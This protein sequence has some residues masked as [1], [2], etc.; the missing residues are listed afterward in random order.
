[1]LL[2]D[3]IFQPNK[4]LSIY[5]PCSYVN[6]VD[7]GI[8][9]IIDQI[10][11][12]FNSDRMLGLAAN[13]IGFNERIF[14]FKDGEDIKT[15]IN[16]E[17][18]WVSDNKEY[19]E[20]GCVSFPNLYVKIK[21]PVE[22]KVRY[23]DENGEMVETEFSGLTARVFQHEMDHMNGRRFFDLASRYHLDQAVKKMK[24]VT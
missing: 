9:E 5:K 12:H 1:M 23:L 16:P 22:I 14:I 18:S 7:D 3:K 8:R 2:T 19:F 6:E 4:N 20:E 10:V 11:F 17:I 21:R 13:Q 24:K 15:A